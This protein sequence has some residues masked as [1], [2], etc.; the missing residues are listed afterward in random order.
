MLSSIVYGSSSIE[1]DPAVV[2]LK[3]S[4]PENTLILPVA[5]PTPNTLEECEAIRRSPTNPVGK[6]RHIIAT[7]FNSYSH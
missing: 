7:L 1:R 5:E 6:V 2:I 4:N 3:G